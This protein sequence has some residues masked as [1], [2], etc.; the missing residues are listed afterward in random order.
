MALVTPDCRH[1]T[2]VVSAPESGERKMMSESE[3]LRSIKGRDMSGKFKL[4]LEF[5]S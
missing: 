2:A 3:R 4:L 1:V 5:V